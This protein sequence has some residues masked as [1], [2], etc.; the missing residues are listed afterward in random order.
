MLVDLPQILGSPPT[1]QLGYLLASHGDRAGPVNGVRM[2]MRS[3]R[4]R[5]STPRRFLSCSK[6]GRECPT[7]SKFTSPKNARWT[8]MPRITSG[9][10]NARM[11]MIA[12]R[13]AKLPKQ[14]D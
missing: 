1:L 10:T 13:G 5:S 6:I 8:S 7:G 9:N 14:L 3:S 12:E 4:A 11:S 2:S